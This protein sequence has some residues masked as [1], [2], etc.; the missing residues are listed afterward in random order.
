MFFHKTKEHP[1]PQKSTVPKGENA[2]KLP[3]RATV[4]TVGSSKPLR[5]AFKSTV[6]KYPQ[7]LSPMELQ[8]AKLLCSGKLPT[9]ITISLGMK[10]DTLRVHLANIRAKLGLHSLLNIPLLGKTLE[11]QNYFA[12]ITEAQIKVLKLRAQCKTYAQ[13][14]KLLGISLSTAMNT[15]S[16]GIKRL[17]VLSK[18]PRALRDLKTALEKHP[19]RSDPWSDPAFS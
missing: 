6:P 12:E 17:G 19:G 1:Q 15:A 2:K 13:I 7:K 11:S 5:R 8:I 18:G 10:C 3:K 9:E 4:G 14:S 16:E